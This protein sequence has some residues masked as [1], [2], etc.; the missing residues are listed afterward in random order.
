VEFLYLLFLQL[1]EF[2]IASVSGVHLKANGFINSVI[3]SG[4]SPHMNNESFNLEWLVIFL[5]LA[6]TLVMVWCIMQCGDPQ[7]EHGISKDQVMDPGAV[8]AR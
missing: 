8:E 7:L 4:I 2:N 3:N 1:D 6:I 5:F